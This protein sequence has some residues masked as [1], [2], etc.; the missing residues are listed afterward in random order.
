MS[1]NGEFFM[2]D[3][4]N[5]RLSETVAVRLIGRNGCA[6]YFNPDG[7]GH[8]GDFLVL[9]SNKNSSEVLHQSQESLAGFKRKVTMGNVKAVAC[10]LVLG[11]LLPRSGVGQSCY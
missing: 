2:T 1:Q 11:L 8:C 4:Y 9:Q 3:D 5:N 6:R 10:F 7:V